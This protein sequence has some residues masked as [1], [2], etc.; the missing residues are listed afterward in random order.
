LDSPFLAQKCFED[1]KT[2]TYPSSPVS[3]ASV[4]TQVEP[5]EATVALTKES[6]KKDTNTSGQRFFYRQST[7]IDRR[8]NYRMKRSTRLCWQVDQMHEFSED[9]FMFAEPFKRARV[10]L[11]SE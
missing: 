3:I 4:S 1:K 8:T 2:Q 7:E 10:L 9:A 11:S 6:P 5:V